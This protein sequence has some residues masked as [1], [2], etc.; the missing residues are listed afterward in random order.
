[1]RQE[2]RET[3]GQKEMRD[4]SRDKNIVCFHSLHKILNS[5][6]SNWKKS[7]SAKLSLCLYAPFILHAFNK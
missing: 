7:E 2:N 1:M 3:E 4:F 6:S 5:Q